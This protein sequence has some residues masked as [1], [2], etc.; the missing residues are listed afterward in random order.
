MGDMIQL[1]WHHK[2]LFVVKNKTIGA[3]NHHL[4]DSYTISECLNE[5]SGRTMKCKYF[6][7]Y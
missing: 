5:K 7:E 1:T 2:T 4:G 6:I 3:L